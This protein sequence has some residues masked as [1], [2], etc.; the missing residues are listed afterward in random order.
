M[1][2]EERAAQTLA[3]AHARLLRDSSIQFGFEAPKPV[4][5]PPSWLIGALRVIGRLLSGLGPWLSYALWGVLGLGVLLV[6][7]VIV[8]ELMSRDRAAAAVGRTDLK[9]R[10]AWRPDAARARALLS[11]ADALSAEGRFT[12]AAHVLLHRSIADVEGRRPDLIAPSL[13]SRDI[14]RLPQLPA[15]P[16]SA[17]AQIARIVEAGVFGGRAVDAQ[18]WAACREAYVRFAFPEAW[19]D[20]AAGAA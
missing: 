6:V 10:D 2:I 13:T 4:T 5:P 1:L 9:G 8:R 19:A 3:A 11:D 7:A 14:S 15:G 16:R 17:F 12:E 18:G 20:A